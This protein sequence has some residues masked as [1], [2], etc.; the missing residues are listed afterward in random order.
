MP[1]LFPAN[2]KILA[3]R[4]KKKMSFRTDLNGGKTCYLSKMRYI[5]F[6]ETV[7]SSA[8]MEEDI[9]AFSRG[10]FMYYRTIIIAALAIL[11]LLISQSS[12]TIINIPA[13]YPTIQEGIDS[14]LNGDLGLAQR[15]TR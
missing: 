3:G 8:Y 12:A 15:G 5:I 4:V 11:T 10:E 1:T 13:D 9:S 7:N 2:V 14:S 6:I